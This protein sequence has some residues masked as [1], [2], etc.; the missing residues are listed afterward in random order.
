MTTITDPE[1]EILSL[2]ADGDVHAWSEL[3]QRLPG[4][5]DIGRHLIALV[6]SG[7]VD[8]VKVNGRTFVGLAWD[9]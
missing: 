6:E 7:Q 4:R 2:L 8:A 9:A 3:R 5:A 1:T